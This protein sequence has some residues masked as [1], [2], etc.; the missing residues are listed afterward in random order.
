MVQAYVFI[1]ISPINDP[2]EVLTTLRQLP[3]VKQTH[4]LLGS[5]DCIT[6]IECADQKALQETFITIRSMQ[7]VVTTDTRSV[8]TQA[9]RAAHGRGG[10]LGLK[11]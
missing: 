7:G 1:N 3:A 6:F 11:A 2:R 9:R 8:H 10:L 5:I 4:L